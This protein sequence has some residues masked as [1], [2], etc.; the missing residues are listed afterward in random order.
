MKYVGMRSTR[1]VIMR[2]GELTAGATWATGRLGF[3]SSRSNVPIDFYA[4]WPCCLHLEFHRSGDY[5]DW[6]PRFPISKM[7]GK[8]CKFLYWCGLLGCGVLFVILLMSVILN[9]FASW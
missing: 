8:M 6:S 5:A 3:R 4:V 9:S 1:G 2:H 7:K